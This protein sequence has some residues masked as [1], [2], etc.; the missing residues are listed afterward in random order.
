VVLAADDDGSE[1]RPAIVVA[2]TEDGLAVVPVTADVAM[3]AEWDVVLPTELLGYRAVAEVWNYGTILPEQVHDLIASVPPAIQNDLRRTLRAARAGE[4]TPADVVTGPPVLD[5][6]D[7]RLLFQDAEADTLRRFWAPVLAL[8]GAATLG[9]LVRHRR[10]E[11]GLAKDI[12]PR[13]TELE[14]DRLYLP[15]IFPAKDLAALMRRLR[16]G[17]SRRLGVLTRATLEALAPALPRGAAPAHVPSP[18]TYVEDFLRELEG[19]D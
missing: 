18:D 15:S 5:D 14:R 9:E 6:A 13:L 3:A 10:T 2:E 12:V 7:P 19:D 11:L 1:L 4:S 17:R 8:S 16:I